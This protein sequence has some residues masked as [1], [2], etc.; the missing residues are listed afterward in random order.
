M[1]HLFTPLTVHDRLRFEQ[2][3]TCSREG[4]TTSL[5]TWAFAPHMIWQDMFAYAWAE[6]DGWWCLFAEYRDGVFMPLPP[7][8]P[9]PQGVSHTSC[10]FKDVVQHVLEYMMT[11]NK[12][13]AVTRIENVPEELKPRFSE[14]GVTL[15]EKD[16]DYLYRRQDL[17]DLKGNRYKAP[18]AASNRFSRENRAQYRSYDVMDRDECLALF[19]RWTAQKEAQHVRAGTPSDI[20]ARYMLE[21]AEPSHRCILQ[22]SDALGLVGRVICVD[23]AIRGYTFGYERSPDVFCILAEVV[24]RTLSGAAQFLFREFC[25][26]MEAYPF[27]NTMD[28]SGLTSLARSKRAYHPVRMLSNFIATP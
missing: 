9:L 16:P 19:H 11:H 10:A 26:D 27:I 4:G 14:L 28:D 21:D 7:L 23:G 18:R 22:S 8:G 13:S 2:A 25:G 5:A 24:D 15:R 12:G 6:I 1:S 20:L 17:V 3:L